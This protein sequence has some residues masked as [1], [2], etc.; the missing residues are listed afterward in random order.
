MTKKHISK[1]RGRGKF[2]R[3]RGTLAVL[4]ITALA[5]TACG[6]NSGG[7]STEEDT[8]AADQG[9]ASAD[10][11]AEPVTVKL[12][13]SFAD[14]HLITQELYAMADAVKERTNGGVDIEIYADSL[15]GKESEMY[16]QL[17]MGTIDM[18]LET[19][20][21]QS[22]THPELTIEDLP[23]MFATREDGYKAL[24]GDYGDKLN[25]IIAS[26]GAVR[27]LGYMELGYRHMTN[28][29]R[30]IEKP[31]D[32][33]GIKFRTTT[34]DLRLAVFEALGAQPISMSF[35]E[36]FTG[37]QQ[38]V[39]DGQESPLSTIDSS[40]FYEVQKYLSLTGH[41]WTN[42]CLLMNEAKWESLPEEWQTI[43]Q[44]EVDACETRIREKNVQADEE[45]VAKMQEKGMEVN[46]VD[47][48]AFVEV[49]KPLYDEWEEKVIGSELMDVYKKY[50]GY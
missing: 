15:L 46:E 11:S 12:G 31:E 5:L 49:L 32:M 24:D 28:N 3:V 2:M 27:N 9:A 35:S 19:I 1:R 13:L 10:V 25:E 44:E 45:L 38:N 48:A 37:L 43:I 47:K 14:S 33:K 20:A 4:T 22:T 18:A 7:S 41:F 34:S 6:N 16:E 8:K 50:A 39:I 26:D 17:Y 23:Y 36:V 29:V 40:S 30:P 42:E 21:F